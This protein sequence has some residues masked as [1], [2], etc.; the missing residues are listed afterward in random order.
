MYIQIGA[1][2]DEVEGEPR[3]DKQATFLAS[4]K[5]NDAFVEITDGDESLVREFDMKEIIPATA[6]A[7]LELLNE[8]VSLVCRND[9]PAL[10]SLRSF[11]VTERKA[12]FS[13]ELVL[14]L[15]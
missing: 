11:G 14:S 10:K 7:A 3:N 2:T 13:G 6:D 9:W 5:D 8:G 15:A 1:I 12:Y 4:A